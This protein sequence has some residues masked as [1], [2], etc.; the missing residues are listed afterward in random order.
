MIILPL[1]IKRARY[2][3]NHLE[4]DLFL[5]EIVKSGDD[6][7]AIVH[8]EYGMRPRRYDCENFMYLQETYKLKGMFDLKNPYTNLNY[9][10]FLY[11]FSKKY[12]KD[13]Q[14]GIYKKVMKGRRSEPL[15]LRLEYPEE[16]Y[17]YLDDV[18]KY[19]TTGKCP[20]DTD[21]QEFG[22]IPRRE[23]TYEQ[24][25]PNRFSKAAVEIKRTLKKER[26]VAL[27]EIAEIIRPRPDAERRQTDSR[28]AVPAWKYPID[29]KKLRNGCLTDT[30]LQKGD[31]IFMTNINK[32][33]LLDSVPKQDLHASPNATVIRPTRICP[34]YLY[35]YLKSETAQIIMESLSMGDISR[36]I[37]RRD[38]E[39]IRVILPK[40]DDEYYK[41]AFRVESYPVSNISQFHSAI[42]KFKPNKG[43][44]DLED[45]LDAEWVSKIR[46]YK[47]DVME[48]YL[49]EDLRE[50]NICFRNKAFK[51]TLILAGS[52]LEA[53]LIDWLSEIDGTN[54]FE[55][56]Y[57]TRRGRKK[58]NLY[59]YI[60]DIEDIKKPDWMEEAEKAHTIRENRNM[61]HAK[62]CIN[63]DTINEELCRQVVGYLE[64]VLKTRKG[65]M[66]K[67]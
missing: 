40:K 46:T 4:K 5:D 59:R 10:V 61:V 57:Y 32:M 14:Y 33:Y 41:Q 15:E 28:F 50:L 54:Y 56:E 7:V 49:T 66:V 43:A 38:M 23:R 51:A 44:K 52:I 63:G 64:D 30:V 26:T 37:T 2:G 48:N 22:L 34:E 62:L 19:I 45:I 39:N 18:E 65:K 6:E 16:Y 53:V 58:G 47:S 29:Y 27:G 35:I 21:S 31:I 9:N 1:L 13:I 24:W 25:N 17:D 8:T 36:R 55:Q 60:D 42:Q 3:F 12:N 11:V 20:K 67:R